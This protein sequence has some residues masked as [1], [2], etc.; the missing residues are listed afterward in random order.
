MRADHDVFLMLTAVRVTFKNIR[1][2]K[3]SGIELLRTSKA[4]LVLHIFKLTYNSL[5][6]GK[7]LD[8]GKIQ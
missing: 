2:M 5:Q 8:I 3:L 1:L 6:T 4:N 7:D